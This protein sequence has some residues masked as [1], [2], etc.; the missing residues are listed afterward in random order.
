MTEAE[1]IQN[2][3]AGGQQREAAADALFRQYQG[4]IK[5]ALKKHK[6][7]SE[8]AFDAYSDT[9]IAVVQQVGAG[10][11]NGKSKLST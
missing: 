1:C 3:M 11:F 2:L 9:I 5:H 4:L 6:L 10:D 8:E 7:T